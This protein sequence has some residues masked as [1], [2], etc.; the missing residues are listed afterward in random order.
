MKDFYPKIYNRTLLEISL[1]GTHDS[2]INIFFILFN[3]GIG[4]YYFTR[5]IGQVSMFQFH[6]VIDPSLKSLF[7]SYTS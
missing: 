4:A 5:E 3:S 1:P 7:Y 2:G 6:F